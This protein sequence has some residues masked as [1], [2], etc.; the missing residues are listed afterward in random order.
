MSVI[1]KSNASCP[2]CEANSK[3][4]A[5]KEIIE[6]KGGKLIDKNLKPK[7]Y[8]EIYKWIC[9]NGH[10]RESKGQYLFEGFWCPECQKEAQKVNLNQK[11][12]KEFEKDVTS[13]KF[14]QRDIPEKYGIGDGVYRRIIS[15]LGLKPK[16]IPQDRKAQ[17]KRTKGKLFQ[18]DPENFDVIKEFESLEA[19]KHDESGLYKPEGVR[20]QMKKYKKA[21]GYYWSR[22]NDYE[23]TMRMIRLNLANNL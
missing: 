9:N 20:Q 8:S 12:L 16:Y 6:L 10:I 4:N 23:E 2:T 7:G 21:Y 11:Q 19:V 17:K 13:G 5:L 15:E 1:I 3:Y 22:A 18:I 14:Y